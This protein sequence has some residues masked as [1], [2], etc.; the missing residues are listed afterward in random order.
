MYLRRYEETENVWVWEYPLEEGHHDLFMDP[1]EQLR[2]RITSQSFTGTTSLNK[3]LMSMGL[4]S[5]RHIVYSIRTN[6]LQGVVSTNETF[7]L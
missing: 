7:C 4:T 2:I 3:T 5:L 1:G 6:S